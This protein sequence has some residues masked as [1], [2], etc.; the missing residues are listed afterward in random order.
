MDKH[1]EE[2]AAE[3]QAIFGPTREFVVHHSVNIK[4]K[5]EPVH[6]I[7]FE[8]KFAEFDGFTVVLSCYKVFSDW[9][10]QLA[11]SISNDHVV[12]PGYAFFV[13]QKID[14]IDKFV[15]SKRDEVEKLV[16]KHSGF[17]MF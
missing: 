14:A 11:T 5:H 3:L 15:K 6:Q 8:M 12:I 16:S 7:T 13:Q 4:D 9:K 17:T 1:I 10:C 2:I